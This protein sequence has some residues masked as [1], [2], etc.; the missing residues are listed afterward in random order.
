MKK[1]KIYFVAPKNKWGTYYYYKDISDYLIKNYSDI[2]D[3]YFCASL[4]EYIKLHFI[5][6]DVIF[7]IVPFLFK[8]LFTKK[9][10]FN[11]HWNYKKEWNIFT[12]LK[13]FKIYELNLWFSD[14]IILVSYYLSDIIWFRKKYNNKI[15][16][17]PNFINEI[18][19]K[20]DQNIEN[21]YNFMTITSFKF[22]EKWKWIINLWNIIHKLWVYY[23]NQKI[24]FTIIWNEDNKI[25]FNIKKDFNKI[26]FPNNV[27]IIWKW[28]IDKEELTN[29][30]LTNNTFIYWTYLDNFPWVVLDA[31]CSNL[32][33]YVNNY[34]CFKYFLDKSIIYNNEKS[35]FEGIINNKWDLYNKKINTNK[36]K[37]KEVIKHIIYNINE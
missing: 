15:S 24:N 22:H 20:N 36:Y 37:L 28:W 17:I 1:K 21:K 3:I 33:V 14:N 23:K 29:E 18:I 31:L 4:R 13:T 30:F 19:Y 11:L 16:I 2:Y 8:P 27:N 6:S 12:L 26:R 5:K 34:P 7:S 35:M 10:N 9:Y 32:K 25:F